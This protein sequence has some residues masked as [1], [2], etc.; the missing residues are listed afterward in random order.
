MVAPFSPVRPGSRHLAVPGETMYLTP[1]ALAFVG[2]SAQRAVPA[3]VAHAGLMTHR[4][5]YN[6]QQTPRA[7]MHLPSLPT[8]SARLG[9]YAVLDKQRGF[10]S[11]CASCAFLPRLQCLGGFHTQAGITQ[12]GNHKLPVARPGFFQTGVTIAVK[13]TA[14]TATEGR[15]RRSPSC[16]CSNPQLARVLDC[17]L[18]EFQCSSMLNAMKSLIRIIY[19]KIP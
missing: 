19:Y 10:L 12:A 18:W 16:H 11:R 7:A 1:H 9:F 3:T 15:T 6:A 8:A 4:A 2:S 13:C 5:L 17:L 14:V